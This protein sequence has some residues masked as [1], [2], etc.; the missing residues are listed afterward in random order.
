[1][2]DR[3]RLILYV[4]SHMWN[5][6]NETSVNITKQKQTHIE[7]KQVVNKRERKGRKGNIGVED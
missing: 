2:S 4:I 5:L 3:K 1:M 7:N 6:K